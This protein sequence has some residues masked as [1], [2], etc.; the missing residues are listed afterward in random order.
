MTVSLE[1]ANSE[2]RS[3]LAV[4]SMRAS[5]FAGASSELQEVLRSSPHDLVA[6]NNLG[7]CYLH[8]NQWGRRG[9]G[10]V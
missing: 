1:P 5:D 4:A 7:L 3:E 10:T 6:R 9:D 2:A 8:E